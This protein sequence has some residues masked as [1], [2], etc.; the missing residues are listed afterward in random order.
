MAITKYEEG[1]LRYVSEHHP[2]TVDELLCVFINLGRSYDK[3]MDS[4]VLAKDLR[5]SIHEANKKMNEMI[6]DL[7]LI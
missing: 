2:H 5:I 7:V 6:G 1:L 3:L 4:V